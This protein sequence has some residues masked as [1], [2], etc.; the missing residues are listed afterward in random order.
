MNLL[1]SF[2]IYTFTT[3][4]N[5]GIGFILTPVLSFFLSPT[6]IGLLALF[7]SYILLGTII[8][9]IGA[10]AAISVNYFQVEKQDFPFYFSAALTTPLVI[11]VL[12]S[13]LVFGFQGPLAAFMEL[14]REWMLPMVAIAFFQ[15]INEICLTLFRVTDKAFLF[16]RFSI[17]LTV[18]N[19][20]ITL[21]LIIGLQ[22]DWQGRALGMLGSYFLFAG[23]SLY[24]FTSRHLF[25]AQIKKEFLQKALVFGVPLIPHLLGTFAIEYSDRYFIQ[26]IEG[27][28]QL[29]IYDMGYKIGMS[30]QIL[31]TA[32]SLTFGPYLFESLKNLTHFRKIR[33]IQAAYGFMSGLLI[34][35]F[36]LGAIGP[37]I[38]YYLIDQKFAAGSTYVFWVALGY[39]F[40]GGYAL[41]ANFIHY[42]GKTYIFSILAIFNITCNL[43]LNYVLIHQYGPI[44]AAYAT[45]VSYFLIFLVATIL[46]NRFYPLPWLH[47]DIWKLKNLRP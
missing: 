32:F 28:E 8:I 18:A 5:R 44:G 12:L 19:I 16:A 33:I 42:S 1:K 38:F 25:R 26:K 37:L 9:G 17:G 15:V 11:F 21:L 40:F 34:A 41:F 43:V 3:F 6:D 45:I 20:L 2:S 10:K 24:L 31:V 22:Y 36:V 4:F 7:N 47:P 39:F 29:G 27:P 13:L 46:A 23:V 30:I 14:P 35:V